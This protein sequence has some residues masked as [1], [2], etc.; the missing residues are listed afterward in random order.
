MAKV[1]DEVTGELEY[2]GEKADVFGVWRAL[3][4]WREPKYISS[5]DVSMDKT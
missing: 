2:R 1:V 4:V 5:R 3:N